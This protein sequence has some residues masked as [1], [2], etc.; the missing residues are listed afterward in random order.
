MV[1]DRRF[2]DAAS[3]SD[4]YDDRV[5]VL[6]ALGSARTV[7]GAAHLVPGDVWQA[8]LPGRHDWERPPRFG[9]PGARTAASPS[10]EELTHYSRTSPRDLCVRWPKFVRRRLTHYSQIHIYGF[11]FCASAFLD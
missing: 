11:S 7:R 8:V 1:V 3:T 10:R 9:W 4:D 2:G 5:G 6:L